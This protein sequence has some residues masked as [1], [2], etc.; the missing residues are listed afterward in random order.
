MIQAYALFRQ[1]VDVDTPVSQVPQL[2]I[3]GHGSVDDPDG[4]V[5]FEQVLGILQQEEF[6]NVAHD[7]IITRLNFIDQ[8]ILE[9]HRQTKY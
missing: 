9:F 5:V 7:I 1:L 4:S 8:L 6:A 2:V 3:A